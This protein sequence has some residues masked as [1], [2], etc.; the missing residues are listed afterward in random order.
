MKKNRA[1]KSNVKRA[2]PAA[3]PRPAPA[4]AAPI[5]PM[6]RR[7]L[8]WGA[9]LVI[10]AGGLIF[11]RLG[12]YPLWVDEADTAL[13]ARGIALT[14]DTSAVQGH[15][16]FAVREGTSLVNLKGRYQPP[17]P[18]YLLAL[19]QSADETG[20]LVPRLPFA[21][22]GL[23]CVVLI[24]VW[25]ATARAGGLA[26]ALAS[27]GLLMN[28]SFLLYCRQC[29]YYSLA[30]L[31]SIGAAYAYVNWRGRRVY[32]AAFAAL[33]I[34]L[35]LTHYLAYAG[36]YAAIGVDYLLFHRKARRLSWG[37]VLAVLASQLVVGIV[38]VSIWNPID[39]GVTPPFPGRSLLADK[40]TL[41]WWHLRDMNACEFLP[42]MA[43]VAAPLVW[44]F[45][46]NP[47]LLRAWVAILVYTL[48]TV[49]LSPQP[50]A[51]TTFADVR[52]LSALIPLCIFLTLAVL[53]ELT[54]AQWSFA[55][56]LALVVCGTNVLNEPIEPAK[57]RSTALDWWREL[58]A[59]RETGMNRAVDY[60]HSKVAPRASVWVVPDYLTYPLMYHAPEPVYAWQLRPPPADQFKNLPRVH[61]QGGA[62]PDY[63][64][65]FGPSRRQVERVQGEYR[66]LGIEY[67]T[68][69][70]INEYWDDRTRPE[71]F[72]RSFAPVTGFN[73]QSEAI[74]FYRRVPAR[75]RD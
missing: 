74:Y 48:A 10:A 29:R 31:L 63:M 38:V 68:A 32:L 47:W 70:V 19:F 43:L 37:E 45:W 8:L 59:G 61:F 50:V 7:Y 33:S 52:Y 9:L 18:F 55:L 13:Y 12:H 65:A 1:Q 15:N 5:A 60:V 16:L 64:L 40:L 4:A 62:P 6:P 21:V 11:A 66:K 67:G 54:R 25:L 30:T 24:A 49:A 72:W 26:W 53:M 42:G 57:W 41:V 34:L 69:E 73:K 56:P 75:A 44:W 71:L 22:C 28:V 46:R 3:P 14:G 20:S 17:A 23:L 58:A 51:I 27:I 39:K 36:L 35:L 2:A